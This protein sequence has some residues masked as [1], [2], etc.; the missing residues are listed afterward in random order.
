MKRSLLL[1]IA[2]IAVSLVLVACKTEPAPAPP[3]QEPPEIMPS[4]GPQQQCAEY[5]RNGVAE[6]HCALCG[7]NI[8]EPF[9]ACTPSSCGIDACTDD[10]GQLVCE[11][12]C[13]QENPI[14]KPGTLPEMTASIRTCNTAADCVRVKADCCGCTMG[15]E[16]ATLNKEY[17]SDW[18]KTLNVKCEGVACIAAMSN[19]WS[20][21]ADIKCVKNKCTLARS[22]TGPSY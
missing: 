1:L 3:I 18:E 22:G 6:Q 20:C 2:L 15:G 4:P 12:D 10:C 5:T 14:L 19:H 21:F 8:C 11:Q 9:E 13:K 7:N 17:R 16:A